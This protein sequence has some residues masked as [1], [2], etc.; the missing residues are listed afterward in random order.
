MQ[1]AKIPQAISV[2]SCHLFRSGDTEELSA[3][4]T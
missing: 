3:E 1:G 2:R 4:G